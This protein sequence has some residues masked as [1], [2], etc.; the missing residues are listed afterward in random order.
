MAEHTMPK[1]K[2]KTVTVQGIEVTVDPNLFDDLEVLELLERVNPVDGSN[3]DVFAF[4]AFLRKV[5]GSQYQKV[6]DVLRDETGRIPM[7]NVAG[8]VQEF[9][10][11]VAPNS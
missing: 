8:F 5:L 6:K 11:K 1:A 4:V 3:P 7:D 10:S 9:M 2:T